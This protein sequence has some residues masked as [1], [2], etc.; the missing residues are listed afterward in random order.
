MKKHV[1]RNPAHRLYNPLLVSIVFLFMFL[2]TGCVTPAEKGGPRAVSLEEAKKITAILEGQEFT[3]P[4]RTI[5]DITKIIAQERPQD[6]KTY[7]RAQ[8]LADS[9]PP[10]TIDPVKLANFYLN[11]GHAAHEVG[12]ADQEIEDYRQAVKYGE[13]E[14]FDC[15]KPA[16]WSLIS[17]EMRTGNLTRGINFFERFIA[18]A[19]SEVEKSVYSALLASIYAETGDLLSAERALT[20]AEESRK[21]TLT[22]TGLK[23]RYRA[24]IDYQI[25]NARGV[26]LTAMGKLS[27]G[28][29]QHRQ[30]VAK[31][32]PYKSAK[33]RL[34]YSP[35]GNIRL[36]ISLVSAL[37]ANLRLQGRLVEAEIHARKAVQEALQAYGR[38]AGHTGQ[39]V[40]EL[41]K[42]IFEQGRFSEAEVLAQANLELFYRIGAA[43]DS[44]ILANARSVLADAILAQRRW[45]EAMEE[46]DVIRK[47]LKTESFGYEWLTTNNVNLWF[48]LIKTGRAAEALKLVRS[49][50]EGKKI[51]L[52]EDHYETAEIRGV[53]GMALAGV[54][55]NKGALKEF[56]RAVPVLLNRSSQSQGADGLQTARDFRFNLIL[57][58]YIKLL[59]EMHGTS[60]AA[61]AGINAAAEAFRLADIARGRTVKRALA[62]SSARAAAKNPDLAD[63]ARREQEAFRQIV[64]LNGLLSNVL[65]G[66]DVQQRSEVIKDLRLRIG[67]LGGARET[68][69]KEIE[70]RF[71]DYAELIDPKPVSIEETRSFLM[72]GEALIA[73]YVGE[74]GTYIWAVPQSGSPAFIST[75]LDEKAITHMVTALRIS[76]DPQGGTLGSIPDF[77]LHTAHKLYKELLQPVEA[78]WKDAKNLLVVAHGAL[79]FLP[80]SVLPTKAAELG[81]EKEPL[82]SN[83]RSIPWLA[84]THTVTSLPSIVSLRTL[85]NLPSA[86]PGRKSFIGF[87]NPYFSLAQVSQ[88]EKTIKVAS[89]GT[90][91]GMP[92]TR[93]GLKK[94]TIEQK[95]PDSAGIDSLPP[96][97]DTA[98]EV[99]GIALALKADLGRD[100]FLGKRASE[101]Q[102]KSL[103]LSGVKVLAFA[104]HGLLPGELDGLSQ[105]ALAL[106][107]PAVT[108]GK[109]D[110]LLNMGEVLSLKL[111]A[112]WVVLSA[113]NTGAGQGAGAEAVSGLGRAFFY[114]GTRALLVSNWPVETTSAKTLTT[115]LFRRQAAYPNL[116][117]A[118]ALNRTMLDLIDKLG[119]IDAEGRMVFSYAHP[120]F[121]APFSLVGDG[122]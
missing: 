55:D 91:R 110:G 8:K 47:A 33:P 60:L 27:E 80:I 84:R 40:T 1:R 90:T 45:K 29:I 43:E 96:L 117:R 7:Q 108:G 53:L 21:K 46:Y 11:R 87:G 38:Y 61:K 71:P 2:V 118:E 101:E 106:S 15:L 51:L 58:V 78:A 19:N 30:A 62:A 113:C 70:A 72:P 32:E 39:I 41:S 103:D 28:E 89:V 94:T 50:L 22:L 92:I 120:V 81:P 73:T 31:H 18:E 111:N 121:W 82:F 122:G 16:K 65:S 115:E 6:L 109:E 37:S 20:R 83:Y 25:S 23:N 49:A 69:M 114:A 10:S 44:A 4:P 116:I 9:K 14:I 98:D 88:K 64:A 99:R 68:I 75:D 119:Y 42:V 3:P 79:G 35:K 26:L 48:A 112:D 56:A 36:Q 76:L 86:D 66:P 52:G 100:V 77:D 59:A 95:G 85:R 57:D 34:C 63:L 67:L 12:R 74:G 93:R 13:R 104:T 54:G 5:N 17:A 102:V 107:S 97:P 24:L 105:P